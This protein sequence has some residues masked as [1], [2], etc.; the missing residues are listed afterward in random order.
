MENEPQVSYKEMMRVL[1]E[2]YPGMVEEIARYNESSDPT[3]RMM[4]RGHW[5]ELYVN[6]LKNALCDYAEYVCVGDEGGIP[7]LVSVMNRHARNI[8]IQALAYWYEVEKIS[9]KY[10]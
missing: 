6:E 7:G 4:T 1:E 10:E 2:R 3:S 9:E 8:V 5:L